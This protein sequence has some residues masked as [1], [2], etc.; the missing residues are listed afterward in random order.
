MRNPDSGTLSSVDN[1]LR[2]IELVSREQSVRVMEVA[3]YL[4]VA[5]S[6]A[7]RLLSA[8]MERGFVVQDSHK[9]YRVGPTLDRLGQPRAPQRNIPDLLRPHLEELADRSG[10]TCHVGVLEGN[11]ARFVMGAA[12]NHAPQ[13]G[14]RIGMLLPAH[15]TAIGRALLA[16]LPSPA[17]R[18]L[19]P[20]GL[21]GDARDARATLLELERQVRTVRKMGYARNDQESDASVTALGIPLRDGSGR[22][23]A[24]LAVAVPAARF[25]RTSVPDLVAELRLTA[26]R[27]QQELSI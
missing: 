22:S 10:E 11:G 23:V 26:D 17:L 24:A 7:H 9:V 3:D 20:R 25:D 5:R 16:E 27:V 14:M 18:S 21:T 1:A 2:I 15:R 13:T 6:T 12:G 4:D 8:L 19:Y